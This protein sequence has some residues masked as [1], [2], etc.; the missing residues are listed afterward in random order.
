M[1]SIL[2]QTQLSAPLMCLTLR[3][4]GRLALTCKRPQWIA[5]TPTYLH[6][7]IQAHSHIVWA[8]NPVTTPAV[9]LP[10]VSLVFMRSTQGQCHAAPHANQ[11]S[12]DYEAWRSPQ[13][14]VPFTP[15]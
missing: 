5:H 11:N 4:L 2:R 9:S 8:R 6:T 12:S 1:K 3:P 15:M 14:D 7:S 13:N 10:G